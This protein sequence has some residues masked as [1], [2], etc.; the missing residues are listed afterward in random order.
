MLSRRAPKIQGI[1]GE[2]TASPRVRQSGL[3]IHER[4]HQA[5]QSG[6]PSIPTVR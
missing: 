4:G 6:F 1:V 2:M 5:R 3:Q